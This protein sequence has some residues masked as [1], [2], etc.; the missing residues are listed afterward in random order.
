M[1]F[2]RATYDCSNF[3]VMSVR[4]GRVIAEVLLIFLCFLLD[5]RSYL[6]LPVEGNENGRSKSRKSW[7]QVVEKED[8]GGEEKVLPLSGLR[9]VTRPRCGPTRSALLSVWEGFKA[10]GLVQIRSW[11]C[12]WG[13]SRTGVC[14]AIMIAVAHGSRDTLRLSHMKAVPEILWDL[15]WAAWSHLGQKMMLPNMIFECY[16]HR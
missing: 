4:K 7:D 9:R 15:T 14:A 10:Q 12:A 1:Q 16:E 2:R 5:L 6:E 3:T 8:D 13:K 11:F